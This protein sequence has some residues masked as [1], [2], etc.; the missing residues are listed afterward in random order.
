MLDAL[1]VD[2]VPEAL[3]I[4]AAVALEQHR[5]VRARERASRQATR[6]AGHRLKTIVERAG[7]AACTATSGSDCGKHPVR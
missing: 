6:E 2:E 1:V 4:G 3:G 5:V 7:G